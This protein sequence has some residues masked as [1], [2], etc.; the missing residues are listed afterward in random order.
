MVAV[1]LLGIVPASAVNET[2]LAPVGTIAL[3]GIVTK[4][5]LSVNWT[6]LF[7]E[8]PLRLSVIVHV[9]EAPVASDD[10]LQPIDEITNWDATKIVTCWET[11]LRVAVTVADW[12]VETV[13]AVPVN[14]IELAPPGTVTVAGTDKTALLL[15]TETAIPKEG[16]PWFNVTVQIREDP[17]LSHAWLQVR[18]VNAR[19]VTVTTPP[20]PATWIASPAVE[21]P[22]AFVMPMSAMVALVEMVMLMTATT[23]FWMVLLFNPDKRHVYAPGVPAHEI[24]LPAAVEAAPV[25]AVTAVTADV[26]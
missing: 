7:E 16:A 19:D 23:P 6:A 10:G 11:P 3:L 9:L 17:E 2:V 12:I 24:D 20:L 26:E 21:D 13:P 14:V 25:V 15:E 18:A 22:R 8:S 4:L 5:L 1:W